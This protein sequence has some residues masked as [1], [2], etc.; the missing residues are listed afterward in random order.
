MKTVGQAADGGLLARRHPAHGQET[1]ILLRFEPYRSRGYFAIGQITAD[2]RA[3][4]GKG[5]VLGGARV[6]VHARH[7]A[8]PKL[9]ISYGDT[10]R[11]EI[12]PQ[13]LFGRNAI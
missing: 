11:R 4:L 5:P 1:Y 2:E 8:S 13:G 12:R 9:I 7:V 6:A 3:E 10:R